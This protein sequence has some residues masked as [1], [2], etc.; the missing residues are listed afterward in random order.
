M[1]VILAIRVTVFLEASGKI[2]SSALLLLL[3][4]QL[5]RYKLIVHLL[6]R[7]VDLVHLS[8]EIAAAV[9]VFVGGTAACEEQLANN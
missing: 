6:H 5:L 9:T 3:S 4:L 8:K 2:T 1:Q 7:V